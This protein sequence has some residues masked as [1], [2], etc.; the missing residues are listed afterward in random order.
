[1]KMEPIASSWSRLERSVA[2]LQLP[3][4]QLAPGA[5]E[6]SLAAFEAAV[7]LRLPDEV[8]DLFR[9]HDGQTSARAGLAGGF[10]FVSLLEARKIMEDWSAV[11][12]K[13]GEGIKDLDRAC[14]SSPRGAIQ[15]KYSDAGWVPLLRDGEG[16]GVGVD[17]NPGP[18]GTAGQIIN[19]GGDED[20]KLVLFPG[21]AALL[22]WLADEWEHERIFY[23]SIDSVI[24]HTNGRLVTAIACARGL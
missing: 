24:R 22:E 6:A 19:F 4:P 2:Q 14:S 8:R 20:D 23:D 7:G 21:A 17:L 12:A 15:R 13:L 3:E 5:E 9:G 18:A 10:H 1:M 11:R 16:N